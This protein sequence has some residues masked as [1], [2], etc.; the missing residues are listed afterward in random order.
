MA[1]NSNAQGGAAAATQVETFTLNNDFNDSE[2]ALTMTVTGEDNTTATAVIDPSGVD[3]TVI[4]AAWLV[5]LQA[6]TDTRFTAITW[7][8]SSNVITGTAKVSGIPFFAA[9][10]V[11]GGAG[12]VTDSETTP[13]TG[14]LDWNTAANHSPSGVPTDNQ[15]VYLVPHPTDDKSYDFRYGLVQT[16]IDLTELR[17]PET[18]RASVGD[19]VNGYYMLIDVSGTGTP[20]LVL[21]GR[22]EA[23]WFKGVMDTIYALRTSNSKNAIQLAGGAIVNL[24]INGANHQGTLTIGSSTD[25]ASLYINGAPGVTVKLGTSLSNFNLLRMDSGNVTLESDMV[26]GSST[27]EV[28]GGVLTVETAAWTTGSTITVRAP[29]I[30][31]FNVGGTLDRFNLEGGQF[32][33]DGNKSSGLTITNSTQWG[34]H[35]SSESGL[36]NLTWSNATVQHGGTSDGDVLTDPPAS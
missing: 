9:S 28:N 23:Y 11:T 13:S 24:Y 2:T 1:S 16:S 29:G 19:S 32:I 21:N 31:R 17:I 14:P 4:A 12:S 3:E 5:A 26:G 35:L 8:V 20:L 7:T 36:G 33:L 22:G 27:I 34:G 25:I 6:S 15:K 18:H 30:V 10:S